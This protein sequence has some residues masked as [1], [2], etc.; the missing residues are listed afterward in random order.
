[1]AIDEPVQ[2]N[3]LYDIVTLL[4]EVMKREK[5]DLQWSQFATSNKM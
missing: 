2:N 1:M 4:D 5:S 3:V